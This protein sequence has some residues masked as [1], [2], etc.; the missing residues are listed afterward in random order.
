[1]R[2]VRKAWLARVVAA[3]TTFAVIIAPAFAAYAHAAGHRH[4]AGHLA[5]HWA[6]SAPAL[7]SHAEEGSGD[8]HAGHG[9]TGHG[10][11]GH[12]HDLGGSDT[13]GTSVDTCNVLC[14]GGFANL[15][16][17][18]LIE[19][20]LATAHAAEP[21][22]SLAGAEPGGLERPPKASVPA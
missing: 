9:Y 15:V 6:Q 3:M 10:H 5:G 11:A 12:G 22:F 13:P 17:T 4:S 14:K 16:A 18:P 20:P 7:G 1:M 21:A 2:R 8:A 19:H